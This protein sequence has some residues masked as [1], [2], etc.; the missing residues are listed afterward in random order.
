LIPGSAPAIIPHNP[1]KIIARRFWGR[2]IV[3]KAVI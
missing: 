3:E 2:K 1:P